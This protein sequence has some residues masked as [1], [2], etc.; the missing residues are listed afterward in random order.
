MK[1]VTPTVE[2]MVPLLLCFS[3]KRS[4]DAPNF[5]DAPYLPTGKAEQFV[6]TK[7]DGQKG[8]GNFL[9]L[10]LTI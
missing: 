3:Q 5:H 9:C 6:N 2:W 10:F 1:H 8:Y 7:E 4:S